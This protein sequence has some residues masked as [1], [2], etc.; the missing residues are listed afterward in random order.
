LPTNLT[1]R[2]LESPRQVGAATVRAVDPVRPLIACDF[3]IDGFEHATP[4][5][6]GFERDGIVNIDHHTPL[7][8]MRRRVSSTNLALERLAAGLV[9]PA[10]AT[11]V[12]NHIDCDSILTAGI[13]SGRLQPEARFGAAAIAADHTG[14][15]DAIADLL[16]GL[17]AAQAQRGTH[18][19]ELSFDCLDRHLAGLP[20]S[21]FAADALQQRRERRARAAALV[22]GGGFEREGAVWFA[23]STS[24]IDGEF[25]PAL[26]PDAVLIL[27]ASPQPASPERW[28]V[29][30]RLGGAAPDGLSLSALG[31]GR[32]DPAHGGRWNAGSNRDRGGTALEP[33]AY[34]RALSRLLDEALD[35]ARSTGAHR[36]PYRA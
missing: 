33:R 11:V 31:I 2:F 18:D 19:H 16:Q 12:I 14:R 32:I 10:D 1:I 15:E 7:P 9:P 29:K 23:R 21:E 3:Y 36:W 17:D 25:F 26:L 8:A 13:M 30:L 6:G 28:Q 5:P 34:A 22:A 27:V 24:A 20:L 35:A 4:V